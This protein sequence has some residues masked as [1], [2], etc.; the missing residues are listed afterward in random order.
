LQL[1]YYLIIQPEVFRQ[2]FSN[3]MLAGALQEGSKPQRAPP[4]LAAPARSIAPARSRFGCQWDRACTKCAKG[5]DLVAAATAAIRAVDPNAIISVNALGQD[6]AGGCA[7]R[8]L[9]LNWGDG[10][11]TDQKVLQQTNISDPSF[12]FE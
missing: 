11:I 10:F 4:K 1:H 8:Y 5:S 6:G 9:G 2:A 3:R 12:L 7:G